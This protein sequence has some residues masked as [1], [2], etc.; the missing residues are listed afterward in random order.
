[1]WLP[2]LGMFA[3]LLIGLQFSLS[4]PAEWSRYTAIAVLAGFDSILGAARAE[5]DGSYDNTTFLSGL[6]TNML[7]AGILTLLGD[8]IGVDL[9]V[10]AIVAFGV[11]VFNNLAAIRRILLK[12]LRGAT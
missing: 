11:R 7:L 10:A 12:R 6:L 5:L 9:S 1:M 4:V 8:R 2:V 3:G